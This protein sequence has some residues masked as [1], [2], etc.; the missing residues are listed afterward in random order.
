MTNRDLFH[1][2][3][4]REN[5]ERL[6]HVIQGFNVVLSDW[7]AQGLPLEIALPPFWGLSPT[8]DLFDH[9]NTCKFAFVG[10]EQF[11][12]PAFPAE[13]IEETAER[14]TQRNSR[15]NIVQ[16]RNDGGAS[17]PHEIDFAIKVPADYARLR[18][19]LIGQVE[20]RVDAAELAAQAPD[21]RQQPDHLVSLWVHGPFAFLRE[22]VGVEQ[23]ILLPYTEPAL[24][25][26]L[27]DDHLQV[28]LACAGP[29]IAATHP[30][31]SYVWEDCCG[32]SGPMVSPPVFRRF[33]LPWYQAWKR[34][35]RERGVP[36][37]V[38]DTDG[39]PTPLVG[40]WIEGGVDCILPWEVNSVNMLKLAERYP[41]LVLMGGIYKHM[42]EPGA[43]EQVGRFA[44]ANVPQAIERELA[45]VVD[46]M[47]RRGGYLPSLDHWVFPTVHYPDFAHYCSM[48][49]SHYGVAN[50]STRFSGSQGIEQRGG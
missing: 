37:V 41:E 45:R 24:T 35:L 48:L 21:L 13:T 43:P 27:L 22:L 49:E 12:L 28:C 34:F 5:G 23:A 2:T 18:E 32:S 19:R 44:S 14:I 50:R 4:R 11:Y 29:I 36:W 3:M 39:D 30:D 7:Q 6:L 40:L 31:L 38:M 9:T 47:R 16:T 1:A 26:Q 33:Y 42:F 46:P 17:L 10:W 25:Q 20:A 8:P 15:G